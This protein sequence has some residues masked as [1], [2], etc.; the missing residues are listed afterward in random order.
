MS[1]Y[2]MEDYDSAKI[3]FEKALEIDST[4]EQAYK[5]LNR[6]FVKTKNWNAAEQNLLEWLEVTPDKAVNYYNLACV[7]S[8]QGE[9]EKGM[10][11]LEM[12]FKKGYRNLD[13]VQK[14]SDIENLRKSENFG[15]LVE[16]YFPK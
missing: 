7:K 3:Y 14:D 2:K 8:I 4:Y 6:L 5:D 1:Y 12:A 11:Y 15:P 9:V 13:K 16:K 10:D